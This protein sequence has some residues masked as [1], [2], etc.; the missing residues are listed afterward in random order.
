M[1]FKAR[2]DL[3]VILIARGTQTTR[4]RGLRFAF[5]LHFTKPF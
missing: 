3:Y 1:H 4:P 5:E 2:F